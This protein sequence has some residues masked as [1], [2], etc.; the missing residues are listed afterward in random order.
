MF[1][2]KL[3]TLKTRYSYKTCNMIQSFHSIVVFTKGLSNLLNMPTTREK[4]GYRP[5]SITSIQN[6]T[7]NG[8]LRSKKLA[9]Y[10][11][12]AKKFPM[13]EAS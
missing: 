13:S 3:V 1:R 12:T 7:K 10:A 2:S 4:F 5:I 11:K 6:F 9:Y 8:K